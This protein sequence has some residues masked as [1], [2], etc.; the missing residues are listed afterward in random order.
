MLPSLFLFSF[1]R[2]FYPQRHVTG[3]K[4]TKCLKT[5]RGNTVLANI[6]EFDSDEKKEQC[7]LF[8]KTINYCTKH[9][10]ANIIQ[11]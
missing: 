7:I 11:K 10:A 6:V 2:M 5:V 4:H 1:A 8:L 3:A 9:D